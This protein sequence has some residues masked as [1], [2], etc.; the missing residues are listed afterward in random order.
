MQ[1]ARACI[2]RLGG[3]PKMNTFAKL[4]LA[5]LGQ[6]RGNICRRC[7]LNRVH[8]RMGSFSTSTR[9]SSWSR[10]MLIPLAILNQYKPTRQLPADKQ[11]HEL[12]PVGSEQSDLGLAGN[13]RPL[14]AEFLPRLRPHS[15]G[16]ARA[17]VETVARH[18]DCQ[19]RGVDDPAHGE[20]SDGSA[21]FFP[22]MLNA[23]IA[24]KTLR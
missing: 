17:P 5:L 13:G 9:R 1:E 16:F 6:F 15:E 14:V 7:P 21:R 24:L 10:A 11:L 4:Y 19:S 23:M 18:R 3:I 20:G 22:A 2:L 12:Y 8:C